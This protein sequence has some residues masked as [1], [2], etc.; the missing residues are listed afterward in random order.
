MKTSLHPV[1]YNN[2]VCHQPKRIAIDW[3]E[4][5]M[6]TTNLRQHF[7]RIPKFEGQSLYQPR[8]LVIVSEGVDAPRGK[9]GYLLLALQ[10]SLS[11]TANE[12]FIALEDIRY[13]K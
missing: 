6:C 2:I 8:S 13:S 10:T 12:C 5:I 1:K 9:G 7:P 3:T 11:S 4:G